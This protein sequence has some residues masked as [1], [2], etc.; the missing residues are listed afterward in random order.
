MMAAAAIQGR[1]DITSN[2]YDA[3]NMKHVLVVEDIETN[4]ITHT[5]ETYDAG[6][7][8]ADGGVTKYPFNNYEALVQNLYGKRFI[9]I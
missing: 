4:S 2:T 6:Y 1:Y 9:E 8:T 7:I 5:I 3:V